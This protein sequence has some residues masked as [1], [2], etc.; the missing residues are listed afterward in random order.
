MIMSGDTGISRMEMRKQTHR[1]H[2]GAVRR[3][4]LIAGGIQI[5]ARWKRAGIDERRTQ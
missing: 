4:E 2:A 1:M 3:D 5:S